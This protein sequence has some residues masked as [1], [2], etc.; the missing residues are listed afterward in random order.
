MRKER[1]SGRLESRLFTPREAPKKTCVLSDQVGSINR[2]RGGNGCTEAYDPKKNLECV[3]KGIGG[4][5]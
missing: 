4:F 1:E 3:R 2:R 5:R